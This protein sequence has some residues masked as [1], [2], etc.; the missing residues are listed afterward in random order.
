MD[1][2]FGQSELHAGPAGAHNGPF[3]TTEF[4]GRALFRRIKFGYLTLMKAVFH[5]AVDFSGANGKGLT[6]DAV[7]LAGRSDFDDADIE[8][9]ELG[10]FNG[11][12]AVDGDAIFRRATFQQLKFDR[13]LF[14]KAVHFEGTNVLCSV[15]LSMVSFGSELSIEDA[16]FPD[17][18]DTGRCPDAKVT[19][20]SMRLVSFDGPVF[21]DLSQVFKSKPWW[22]VWGQD[23]P[24]LE[25]QGE[26][27]HFWRDLERAFQK[28]DNLEL[29]NEA[30]Y[31]EWY[32]AEDD[33]H[34]VEW[35]QSVFSRVFW[36]Y[37][38]TPMRVVVW[39]ALIILVFAAIYW[40][41]IDDEEFPVTSASS[42]LR[43]AKLALTFSS[44][45]AWQMQYGYG[46]SRTAFFAGITIAE[47][48]LGKILIACFVYALAQASPLLSELVKKILP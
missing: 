11:L 30:A 46:H 40:T 2:N 14:R 45:T 48:I 35:L 29:K 39:A 22:A 20:P 43:R 13:V 37:G 12:A 7:T 18:E 17:P 25:V 8:R 34:G 42:A 26:E 23:E 44:R 41:Q 36:G 32:L 28:A 10:G 1:A 19:K 16:I 24:R 9:I 38:L 6:F 3:Y 27:K 47:S 5:D 15:A 21:A 31:R 4:S 33:Q